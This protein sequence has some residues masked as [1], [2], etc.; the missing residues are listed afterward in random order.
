ML[1]T[2]VFDQGMEVSQRMLA[3]MADHLEPDGR[4]YFIASDAPQ[5]AGYPDV[6][7]VC[8]ANDLLCGVCGEL[9]VGYETYTVHVIRR[10]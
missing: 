8:A 1:E 2:A 9:G 6:A 3:E 5:R 10:R 4:L 7:T